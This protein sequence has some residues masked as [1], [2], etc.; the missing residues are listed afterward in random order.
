[1]FWNFIKPLLNERTVGKIR[2]VSGDTHEE[3]LRLA[4]PENIPVCLVFPLTVAFSL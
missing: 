3:L 4:P 2:I 1:M